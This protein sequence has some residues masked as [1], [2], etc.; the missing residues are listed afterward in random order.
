MFNVAENL[1]NHFQ[2]FYA[3]W[4]KCLLGP[5]I[6][7]IV[8]VKRRP[9]ITRSALYSLDSCSLTIVIALPH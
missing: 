5:L 7:T 6:V 8:S 1:A 2:P 4:F 3:L 9:G